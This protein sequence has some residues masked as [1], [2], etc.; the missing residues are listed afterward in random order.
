[1]L[2]RAALILVLKWKL[3][4]ISEKLLPAPYNVKI[5]IVT[6]ANLHIYSIQVLH[7]ED[8]CPHVETFK[9]LLEYISL[10]KKEKIEGKY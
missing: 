4:V 7:L 9:G 1:M 3:F 6:I 10:F 2:D 5:N 8:F